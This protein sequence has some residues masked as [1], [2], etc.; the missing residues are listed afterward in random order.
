MAAPLLLVQLRDN[1]EPT[2]VFF[3]YIYC[4]LGYLLSYPSRYKVKDDQ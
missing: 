3:S 1:Q 2:S 4:P